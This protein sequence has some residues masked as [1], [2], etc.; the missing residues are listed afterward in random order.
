MQA[1]PLGDPELVEAVQGRRMPASGPPGSLPC[2]EFVRSTA[3][4]DVRRWGWGLPFEPRGY[5]WELIVTGCPKNE[6][7]TPPSKEIARISAQSRHHPRRPIDPCA[8]ADGG[9]VETLKNC[10]NTI[11]NIA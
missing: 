2:A 4:S 9:D 5:E 6:G 3:T 7:E 11:P 1:W 8:L 10:G